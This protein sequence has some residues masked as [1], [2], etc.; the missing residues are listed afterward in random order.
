MMKISQE[1]ITQADSRVDQAWTYLYPKVTGYG[2]YMRYNDTLP[3]NGG[4]TIFQ[5][6]GQFQASVVLTQPLYTGGRALAALRAAKTMQESS[7]SDLLT[8][9]QNILFSVAEAFYAIMRSQKIVAVSKDALER[10]ER[11]R[12]VTDRE[13]STRRSK[14]NVSALLRANTLVDQAKT[15]LV[16]AETGLRVAR[17][18]FSLL[19]QLP[20]NAEL[21]EPP[22]LQAGAEPLRGLQEQALLNRSD[23]VS[24]QMNQKVARENVNITAGAHYPQVYAQG[25]LKYMDSDPATMMDA[26]TYYGGIFL[27][28]PIFEGG[29]MK[30]E[31][32]ESRS[33]QRQ[34]ELSTE[35]LKRTL[36]N[37]VTE[38]YINYQAVTTILE[39]TKTQFENA[40]RNF[41]TVEGLFAEGL[42]PSL[43]VIDAQQ[44]LYLAER[45]LVSATYEQQLSLV[46][47]RKSMGLLGKEPLPEGKQP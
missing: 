2:S 21:S 22:L 42:L 12:M 7:H 41:D 9:R 31:V 44:A 14:A 18:R 33:K 10:M 28:V 3:P 47:L 13:A 46:R 17:Q 36:M 25:G 32:A 8:S 15:N 19:T 37:D 40:R 4:P 1:N 30:A 38:A 34:A 24:S 6:L 26:T 29:L 43:S 23:Y 39:T 45:E 27:Q 35:L 20:E 11:H 5:P 16:L